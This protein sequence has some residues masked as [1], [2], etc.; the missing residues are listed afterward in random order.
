[1][2]FFDLSD[3]FFRPLWIRVAV[4]GTCAGWG[5]FEFANGASFWGVIFWA[6]GGFAAW[7]F[8]TVDYEAEVVEESG[9]EDGNS[10]DGG[11]DGG[12]GGS[13]SGD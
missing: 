5:L 6:M 13:D 11:F 10:G 4:V 12:D 1:M 8:V 3:S 2:K 7:Q 9:A